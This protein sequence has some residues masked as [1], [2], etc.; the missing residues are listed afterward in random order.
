MSPL[1]DHYP[2]LISP[3]TTRYA[4]SPVPPLSLDRI[5]DGREGREG[6]SIQEELEEATRD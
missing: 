1:A 4:V 3:S 2:L 5:R 6:S